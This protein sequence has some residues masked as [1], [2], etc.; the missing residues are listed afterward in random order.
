V[1]IGSYGNG[2]SFVIVIVVIPLSFI[3]HHLI[4]SLLFFT[5]NVFFIV[6]NNMA[7]FIVMTKNN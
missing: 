1:S 7:R 3:I 4:L 6:V 5:F 2:V